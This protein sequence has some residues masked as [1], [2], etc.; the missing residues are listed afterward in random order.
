VIAPLLN[1]K[2]S[3]A[4]QEKLDEP[5]M[6]NEISVF[7]LGIKLVNE[8]SNFGVGWGLG[9]SNRLNFFQ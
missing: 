2:E 6:T 1:S 5:K 4:K 3:G 7:V 8:E 9:L